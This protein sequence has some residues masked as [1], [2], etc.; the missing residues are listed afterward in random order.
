MHHHQHG[1]Q[2]VDDYGPGAVEKIGLRPA[3][4]HQRH[5]QRQDDDQRKLGIAPSGDFPGAVGHDNGPFQPMKT[6]LERG[7]QNVTH[8]LG[9]FQ[10]PAC[11]QRHA[12]QR[13]VRDGDGKP[14]FIAQTR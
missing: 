5:R 11:A 14:G 1:L 12:G 2:S 13:I 8:A 7:G 6:V 9:V 3:Q 10:N 4:Q